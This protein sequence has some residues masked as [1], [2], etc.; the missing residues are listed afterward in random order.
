M[1][2]KPEDLLTIEVAERLIDEAYLLHYRRTKDF[3]SGDDGQIVIHGGRHRERTDSRRPME[4]TREPLVIQ[5]H[6]KLLCPNAGVSCFM[7]RHAVRDLL[8]WAMRRYSEQFALLSAPAA[9]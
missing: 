6:S 4:P 9:S 3:R 7:G 1:R 8:A 2:L 5:V